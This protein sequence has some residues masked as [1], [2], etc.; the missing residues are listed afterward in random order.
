M[1][2]CLALY[3]NFKEKFSLLSVPPA[4]ILPNIYYK[5]VTLSA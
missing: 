5:T 2:T 4:F 1:D 3:Q